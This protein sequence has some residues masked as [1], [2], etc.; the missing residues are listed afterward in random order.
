[1]LFPG[2]KGSSLIL[3]VVGLRTGLGSWGEVRVEGDLYRWFDP[4]E[5]AEVSGPGDWRV[6][7]KV[8]LG[9][10]DR[11]VRWAAL[12]GVKI[13][14]ASDNDGLGT[15]LADVEARALMAIGLGSGQL[16]LNLGLAVLG[17]TFRERAQVDVAT[18]AAAY[19][20]RVGDRL[21]LD[22]EIAGRE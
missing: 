3:P 13:P 10:A 16:D 7:T 11:R 6:Q 1:V 14:V 9:P 20:H 19:C 2:F 12:L 18:Y 17:A 21:E 4:D 15:N 8:R 5:D 22:G